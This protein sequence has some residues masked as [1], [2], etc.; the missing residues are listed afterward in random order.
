MKHPG[1]SGVLAI[2]AGLL[3]L[4]LVLVAQARYV[5]DLSAFMPRAPDARQQMLL[6]QLRDGAVARIVMIGIEG[7]DAAAR[8]KLSRRMA[9]GLRAS[10]QFVGVLNGESAQQARDAAWLF[11]HRYVLSPAI[12]P[13][14]FSLAGLHAAV[15]G[16]IDSLSG[17]MGTLTAQWFARDPTGEMQVLAERF[18]AHAQ[19]SSE[20]GVWVSRDG[21]RAVLLAYTTAAGSD[22]E[23]QARALAEIRR[24]FSALGPAAQGTRLVMSGTGVLSVASRNTIQGTVTRLASVSLL[25]VVAILFSV[26]RSPRLLLAGLLPVLSGAVAGIAMVSLF[27]AQVHALTLGFGTTLI[28]EAVDYSIYFFLQRGVMREEAH[29]WRTLWL[30]VLT[31]LAGFA[32]LLFSAFPGLAQLGLYSVSGLTVAALVTRFVL[33]QIVAPD[34]VRLRDLTQAGVRLDRFIDRAAGLRWL[35]ILLVVGACVGVVT[36]GG[37]IWNRQLS[38]LSPVSR[39]DQQLDAQLRSDMGAPDARYFVAIGA[40]DAEHALQQAE[41]VDPLLQRLV[42]A[43]VIASYDSPAWVLP[44]QKLQRWRQAALPDAVQAPGLLTAALHGLPVQAN[45]LDGFLAD[46]EAA[47]TA[48]VLTRADLTGTSFAMLYDTMF[49]TRPGGVL[50]LIPLQPPAGAHGEIAI[51]RIDAALNAAGLRGIVVMDLLAETS[52]IFNSYLHEALL[53][54]ALGALAICVLLFAALRR[55]RRVARILL[56][57]VATV[58]CVTGLL[59]AS[60]VQLTILHLI[61]LLL[62]VAIGSNYALFFERDPALPDSDAERRQRQLSLVVANL[63]TVCSF[64][65]L[66]FSGVPVLSYIGG[67]VGMGTW[68]ALV[69]AAVFTRRKSDATVV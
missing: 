11:S 8:A 35:L 49:I 26:Y 31:S 55:I 2:W 58:V 15:A 17:D 23:A 1:R 12:R 29:F 39:A 20:D 7:G 59:L 60:G 27:F 30:G 6:D 65:L 42:A 40:A 38:A 51:P 9:A 14:R 34:S 19:P 63:T 25:L 36:H 57:L 66:G 45:R 18:S 4:G 10:G 54:C 33:P 50:L 48:P 46:L 24:E 56:P 67:T 62:T 44:S 47:R 53:L 28:G 16:S 64:S 41:R 13:E 21:A 43:R 37:G 3:V 52:G 5:A 22:T 69:F 61:G 32:A 68:L